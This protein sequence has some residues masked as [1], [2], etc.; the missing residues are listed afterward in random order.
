M[1][2]DDVEA[3]LGASRLIEHALEYRPTIIGGRS[4]W[5]NKFFCHHPALRLTI[6]AGQIALGGNRDIPGSLTTRTDAQIERDTFG[7]D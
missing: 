6:T 5:L 4:S 2:A 1:D 3:A 7:S